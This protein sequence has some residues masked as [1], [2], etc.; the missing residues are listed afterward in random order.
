MIAEARFRGKAFLNL[1]A[2]KL[3]KLKVSD[4]FKEAVLILI[5]EITS[6][7]V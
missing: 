2:E 5:S 7:E 4:G 6:E 1:N 3:D